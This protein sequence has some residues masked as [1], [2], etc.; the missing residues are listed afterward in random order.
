MLYRKAQSRVT[1][2]KLVGSE[3]GSLFSKS[4]AGGNS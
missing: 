3:G 2:K 4:L 1:E